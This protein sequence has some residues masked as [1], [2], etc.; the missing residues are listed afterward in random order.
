MQLRV[1]FNNRNEIDSNWEK[2]DDT[3]ASD[4]IDLSRRK[5]HEKVILWIIQKTTNEGLSQFSKWQKGN[6][7]RNTLESISR[8]K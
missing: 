3:K 6:I 2:E 1:P 4:N 7:K 8:I 5:N